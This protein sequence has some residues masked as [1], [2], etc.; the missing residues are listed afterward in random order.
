MAMGDLLDDRWATASLRTAGAM[1][2]LMVRTAAD[3][4]PLLNVKAAVCQPARLRAMAARFGEVARP[5]ERRKPSR[6][7]PARQHG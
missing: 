4:E 1:P 3:P 2:P 5:M 7:L 6:I